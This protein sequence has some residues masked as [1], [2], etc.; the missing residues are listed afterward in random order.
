MIQVNET[1]HPGAHE[2]VSHFW[3]HVFATW[4]LKNYCVWIITIM[5]ITTSKVLGL[6][7]PLSVAG[8]EQLTTL[9]LHTNKSL[10]HFN[11]LKFKGASRTH[12]K[13]MVFKHHTNCVCP[14]SS[15]VCKLCASMSNQ[16]LLKLRMP[17]GC[18]KI[19]IIPSTIRRC[20]Q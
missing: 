17:I 13:N 15:E 8:R 3:L 16:N 11:N 2:H 6:A 4:A 19:A 5:T 12:L 10:Q 9:P 20:R 14:Q 18:P 1:P 7:N